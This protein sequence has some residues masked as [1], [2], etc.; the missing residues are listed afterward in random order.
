MHKLLDEVVV[1]G[2]G[3]CTVQAFTHEKNPRYMVKDRHG[4]IYHDVPANRVSPLQTETV[5]IN[6]GMGCQIVE[7]RK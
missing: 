2:V 3:L 4:N 1:K 7:F 6:T 5:A